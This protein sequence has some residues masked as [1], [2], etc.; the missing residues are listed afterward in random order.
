MRLAHWFAPEAVSNRHMYDVEQKVYKERGLVF[1]HTDNINQWI[2]VR[3]GV[4]REFLYTCARALHMRTAGGSL[5]IRCAALCTSLRT[6]LTR[7]SLCVVV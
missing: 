1:R 6:F 5:L 2:K 7:A 4:V 3:R